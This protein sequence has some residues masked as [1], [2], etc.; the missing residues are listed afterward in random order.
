[1]CVWI[2]VSRAYA[3][4]RQPERRHRPG[5]IRRSVG[6]A[7]RQRLAQRRLVD[8]DDRD[9]RRL[10]VGHLVAQG[11]RDLAGGVGRRLV[12][13][14]ERP[15]EH[16]DRPGEHALDRPVG[17]R[18]GVAGPVD[19]HRRG[20]GDVAGQDRRPDVAGAVRLHPAVRGGQEAGQL[21]GE[22]LHHVVALGL[23][24]HERRPARSTP[25][26]ATTSR[27]LR[28]A[29]R[30]SYPASR[31]AA[32]RAAR[33]GPGAVRRSAGTSRSW[34]S[35]AAAGRARARCAAAR[36]AYGAGAAA[37]RVG[38]GGGARADGRVDA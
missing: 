10:Q 34:W 28:R 21:L 2:W 32:R 33:R 30:S 14:D 37:V 26:S 3:A 4:R 1:M 19:G 29:S 17:E 22:V 38:D 20:P 9:A 18:L 11:E 23:A 25:G 35:A 6:R 31:R 12:V 5:Q 8:L 27:D 16:R 7:Q 15:G 24:V 13:A 36:L